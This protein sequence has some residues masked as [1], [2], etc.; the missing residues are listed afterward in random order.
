[1]AIRY[2]FFNAVKQ[3]DGTYDRTYSADDISECFKS[4]VTNGVYKNFEDELCVQA[5]SGMQVKVGAG[6]AIVGGKWFENTTTYYLTVNPAHAT[7]NR[8]TDIVIRLDSSARTVT[9]TTKDGDPAEE[10]QGP[11]IEGRELCLATIYV[12]KGAT[13]ISQSNITDHRDDVA[14]CGWVTTRAVSAANTRIEEYQWVFSTDSEKNQVFELDTSGYNYDSSDVFFVNLNGI[15]LVY[16]DDYLI[17]NSGQ[18]T[19]IHTLTPLTG[20]NRLEVVVIKTRNF[21]KST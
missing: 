13:S 10:P 1:M 15:V 8:K 4:L 11:V 17:D 5:D 9:I 16:G 2:G 19:E 12:P 14:L 18:F 21:R 6:R 7:L 3:S 20:I